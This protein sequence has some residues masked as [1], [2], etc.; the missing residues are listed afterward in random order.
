MKQYVNSF[1]CAANPPQ[2]EV[3]L[4]LKQ[5]FPVFDAT[6]PDSQQVVAESVCSIVM[7][8]RVARALAD[9]LTQLLNADA[10]GE[11]P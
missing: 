9:T 6:A 3:V 4:T 5:T 11:T 10:E 8:I 1:D 2:N 7:N